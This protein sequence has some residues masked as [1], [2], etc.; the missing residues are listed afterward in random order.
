MKFIELKLGDV[1]RI[2]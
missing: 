1:W 2:S